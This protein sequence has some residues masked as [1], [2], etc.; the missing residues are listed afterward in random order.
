MPAVDDAS[1]APGTN[2]TL[3]VTVSNAGTGTSPATTLN[4]YR[5]TDDTVSRTDT[6]VGTA[7]VGALPA[8]GTSAMSISL[9]A[10]AAAAAQ[11]YYYGACVEA[12]ADESDTTDNCST[13][14][15]VEVQAPA[16]RPNLEVG[17]PSVDDNQVDPGE[18]FTLSATVTNSGN[19]D[20]PATTLRY[21]RSTD[22]TISRLD[23]QVGTDA[24]GALPA[25]GTSA[26]SILLAVPS[27]PDTYYY[28]A[29]VD[30]VAGESDT[31][32]N[33]STSVEVVAKEQGERPDLE[34]GTPTVDD[35][36]P[37]GG[38]TFTL[39]ATVTNAGGGNSPATTLRYY[40]STND[41][42]SSSDTQVGT[43]PVGVLAASATSAESISLAAPSTSG[44]YYYG[45]CVDA[46][47]GESD[48]SD[49]CSSSVRIDVA[50]SRVGDPGLDIDIVFVDPQP[51]AAI[52]SAINDAA[53]V[54]EGAIT[55]DLPDMDFSSDPRDD[56]CTDGEFA[57]FVDDVR[58]Y[59]YV[60]DIDGPDGTTASA[61]YCMGRAGTSTPII[62]RIRFDSADVSRLSTTT[63]R[64][65]AVHELAHVLGFGTRWNVQNRSLQGG[66]P[67]DPPPDTHWPGAN[68]V[69]AFD[70]AGGT[71][72]QG[73]KVPVENAR[74]GQG[75]QDRHWRL[76]VFPGEVMTY[77]LD[78]TALSAITIRSMA[79]LGFIVDAS[80]ADSYSISSSS[81]TPGVATTRETPLR[82][83]IDLLDV[84]YVPVAPAAFQVGRGP[85][86]CGTGFLSVRVPGNEKDHQPVTAVDSPVAASCSHHHG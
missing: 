78:G 67:V 15:E 85:I 69:A 11:K 25:S 43:D 42:I 28:G 86:A 66:D 16:D 2:F 79:D 30:S 17:T 81:G 80:K 34:V 58:V 41:T 38:E 23:T 21:Y 33:C 60:V 54:W 51:S 3:S 8:S 39:S 65:V 19:G 53:A 6:Q 37:D 72:Y 24:V 56:A 84:E 13:S 7:V 73:G 36:N 9:T 74:G 49:N 45:A 1:P 50:T 35:A 31:T 77:N 32:D 55:N 26:E 27:T 47:A 71:S 63:V 48:T 20:S 62:G 44:T 18:T 75:S 59:I 76:S 46:V 14:V 4:Y 40:R 61:G 57:G 52:R 83:E 10:P 5:S 22:A 68:A 64:H 70:A 82:C 29:C 12:V